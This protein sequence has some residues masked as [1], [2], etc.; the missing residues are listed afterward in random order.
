MATHPIRFRLPTSYNTEIGR[1]I[2]HWALLEWRIRSIAY[3]LL[4][5][6]PKR[7]RVA[8]REVR[9][10]MYVTMIE[11]L[12]KIRSIKLDID[13]KQLKKNLEKL[14][15]L[16]NAIAHGIWVKHPQTLKPVLQIQSHFS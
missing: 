2:Q 3:L 16:R 10:N 4:D 12:S 1:I 11:D 15:Y 13:T 7:G 5:L 6:D 8:V 9:I 14:A